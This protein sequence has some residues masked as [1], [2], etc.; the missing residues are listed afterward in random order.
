[1]KTAMQI[2]KDQLESKVND[3]MCIQIESDIFKRV[4]NLVELYLPTEKQQII[5]L[6][7]EAY[8]LGLAHKEYNALLSYDAIF[9]VATNK[10]TFK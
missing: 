1:M 7:T 4:S 6:C 10:E 5:D 9:N 3:P 8:E 2:L